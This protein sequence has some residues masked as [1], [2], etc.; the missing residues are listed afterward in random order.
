MS[1][2]TILLLKI[3]SLLPEILIVLIG[4]GNNFIFQII[5]NGNSWHTLFKITC[6][7]LIQSTCMDALRTIHCLKD[8]MNSW[9]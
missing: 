9:D 1:C 7:P 6:C 3:V 2:D 8:Q 5:H 4:V